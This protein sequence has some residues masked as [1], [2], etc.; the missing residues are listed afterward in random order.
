[1]KKIFYFRYKPFI[2]AFSALILLAVVFFI[3]YN[4]LKL[5]GVG[6]LHSYYVAL[7]VFSMILCLAVAAFTVL[8]LT[9]NRYIVVEDK[10]IRQKFSKKI[11]PLETTLT[12]RI[13]EKEK[14]T[15]LY[16]ADENA[17]DGIAFEILSVSLK[18]EQE[19]IDALRAKNPHLSI[20][21]IAENKEG[22]NN[23]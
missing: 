22:T 2:Y 14:M 13:D 10:L 11:I 15:V 7:D 1:M 4:S 19:L 18:K 5:A 17:T 8:N 9:L 12:I 6:Y 21:R 23:G 16:Y 20:E 3:I